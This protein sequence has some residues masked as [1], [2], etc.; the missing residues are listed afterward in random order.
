VVTEAYD[1]SE[2]LA[3][4]LVGVDA[5]EGVI[6]TLEDGTVELDGVVLDDG[7]LDPLGV[8]ED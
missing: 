7:A 3:L 8:A 4:V 1:T 5:D 6:A 2:L